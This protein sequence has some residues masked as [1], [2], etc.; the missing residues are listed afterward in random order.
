MSTRTR[1][2]ALSLAAVGA[3][4]LTASLASGASRPAAPQV[5]SVPTVVGYG[6]Q[7]GSPKFDLF[8]VFASGAGNAATGTMT[9]YAGDPK[10]KR[11]PRTSRACR[12]AATT[13]S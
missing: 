13:R 10:Q 12:S 9:F 1:L 6:H 11:R 2:A 5:A 8:G 3:T 7:T 4:A